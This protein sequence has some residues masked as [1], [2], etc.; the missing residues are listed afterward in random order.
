MLDTPTLNVLSRALDYASTRQE[1]LANNIANANTP[2][3]RRKEASF[4]DVLAT[5]EGGAPA[6]IAQ[7]NASSRRFRE[8]GINGRPTVEVIETD[9]GAMRI[10]GNN[11]DMDAE[12]S[13]LAQNQIYYDTCAQLTSGQFTSLKS[14]I[15][16]R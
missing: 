12:M 3:Y 10:D 14:V 8:N 11:V 2:G 7:I 4:E 13:R 9:D 16:G 6:R 15:E 1:V 5:A